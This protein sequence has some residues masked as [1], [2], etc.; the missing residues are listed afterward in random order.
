MEG[1]HKFLDSASGA[2]RSRFEQFRAE[3]EWWLE[4]FVLYDALRDRYRK[5]FW[6][7]WPLELARRDAGALENAARN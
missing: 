1:A 7:A 5:K 6:N 4:D 2:A 3:N